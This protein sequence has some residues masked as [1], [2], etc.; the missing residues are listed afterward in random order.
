M[1]GHVAR[2]F[3]DP[4]KP[5]CVFH[6]LHLAIEAQE[7]LRTTPSVT[8]ART[9]THVLGDAAGLDYAELLGGLFQKVSQLPS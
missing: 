9:Y 8:T 4:A 2:L 6:L 5:S 3:E 7:D 1:T